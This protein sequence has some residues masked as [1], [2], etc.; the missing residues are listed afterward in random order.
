MKKISEPLGDSFSGLII[1]AYE[2]GEGAVDRKKSELVAH[3][4]LFGLEIAGVMGIRNRADGKLLD[5]LE[6]VGFEADDFSGIVREEPDF[7]NTE[8]GENLGSE[9][10]IAQ[11]HGETE[12][13]I[14]FHGVEAL[15]LQFVGTDFW[16]KANATALL[17]H[18]KEHSGAFFFDALHGLVELGSTVAATGGEDIPREALAVN[19]HQGRLG[20]GNLAFH[21]RDVVHAI[22]E[23]TVEVEVEI[24]KVGWHVDCLFVLHELLAF[25]AVSDEVLDG[26]HLEPMFLFEFHEIRQAGHGAIFLHDFANDSGGIEACQ[27]RQVNG[28]LGVARTAQDA[29]SLRLKRENMAGLHEV[30][31][32]GVGIGEQA[33]RGGAVLYTDARGD[34]LGGIHRDGEI[35]FKKFTVLGDH[36]LEAESGS[37]LLRDGRA[38]EAAAELC[39]EIDGCGRDLG[40]G[41]EE[42]AFVLAVSVV[43]DNHHASSTDVG[44][45]FRN[46]IKWCFHVWQS[47]A[48]APQTGKISKFRR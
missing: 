10:I 19:A 47:I 16:S 2:K 36:S 38:D 34:S 39:H 17:S 1:R 20:G 27:A 42:I 30:G 44:N 14:G 7:M 35:G 24:A 4:F 18:V 11:V 23:R 8:V 26:T 13:L 40:G 31:G 3:F 33:D 48:Q 37:A 43:G 15:L 32:L 6:V 9:A 25:T 22:H 28:S 46:R 29:A 45:D 5:D 21:K 12:A 41:H